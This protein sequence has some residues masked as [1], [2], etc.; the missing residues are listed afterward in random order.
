MDAVRPGTVLAGKY[1]IERVLGQGGMGV[2]VAAEHL[3]LAQRVALKFLLPEACSNGQ[4]VARFLR[5]ARAAVQIQS[6]HV[7]RV[8]DVGQLETGAPYMVME[9]L[10]GSDLG[11]V[12]AARGPLPVPEAVDYV[13]Q[14]GEAIAE[15]HSLG[16][17]H[18]D[19]KPANLFLTQ[20]RD[21][22]PLVKVLDF[23]ISKATQ[24]DAGMNLTAT[25][26]VMG[27]PYYMSPEQ[28]RSAKD[29]DARADIWA[30][31]VILQ[32][33]V[34]GSPPFVAETASALFASIIADTPASVRVARPDLPV[35]L[36]QLIARC[37]EKDR[38]RRFANMAELA[39]ALGPFA[40][41]SANSVARIT[42][43]LGVNQNALAAPA[44]AP[45]MESAVAA[46]S[47]N[48]GPTGAW[49]ATQADQPRPSR[50]GLYALLAA[51]GLGLAGAGLWL[52]FGREATPIPAASAPVTPEVTNAAP[53]PITPA[54]VVPPPVV[55]PAPAPAPAP[56]P[57]ASAT[58]TP[59]ATASAKPA[60]VTAPRRTAPRPASTPASTPRRQRDLFD[61]TQ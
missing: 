57:A 9:F 33:L 24:A 46:R 14:A 22:S 3:Q 25:S 38:N 45:T 49:G 43:V 6:E 21:G 2:V 47:T 44:A 8:S 52:A 1:R 60:T 59:S 30:L 35:A 17:V 18:R 34:A 13:L 31:G 58:A 36:E 48:T 20:R 11:A 54:P 29:V 28:V 40:P 4:A 5:E 27:S 41:Q 37:L 7:A 19:L 61:D 42:R 51:A 15:A 55:E 32:E 26:A 16:I 50:A 39:F 53:P 23:G 10:Q 56:S 12:L